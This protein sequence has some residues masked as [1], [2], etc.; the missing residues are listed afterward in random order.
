MIVIFAS[1]SGAHFNPAVSA[2]LAWRGELGWGEAW[3]YVF[4]Q[5]AGAIAGVWIANLM[6]EL[7]L[8]Q[9]SSTL[10]S[11]MGQ[12]IAE[13]VPTFG[14]LLTILGCTAAA[15]GATAP[16]VG[17]YI[18]AAY[19]FTSS[20]SFA[21]PAATLARCLSDSFAGIAP[22]SAPLFI[23]AQLT[24]TVLAVYVFG[25]L[26]GKDDPAWASPSPSTT[27]RN[28]APPATRSP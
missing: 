5:T 7:P 26:F 20:T 24:G 4:C 9:V 15:P 14:L 27:T 13:A 22:R 8:L 25:W 17:L 16:A 12:W 11:G 28:A 10:R 3:L 1:V 23:T 18:G 6:F 2:A 21:N 19:W